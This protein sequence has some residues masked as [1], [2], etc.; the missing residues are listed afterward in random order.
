MPEFLPGEKAILFTII[1]GTSTD[2]WQI[3]AQR[4]DTGDRKILV[5][6]GT[7]GRYAS[8]GP[9]AGLRTGHLVYYRSGTMMATPFDPARLELTGAPVPVL[10][11]VMSIGGNAAGQ[12]SFSSLGSLVYIPTAAGRGEF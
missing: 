6:G 8:T 2:D 4:L 10:E 1:T 9:S 5:R 7:Y 3:A 12:Y 11:D